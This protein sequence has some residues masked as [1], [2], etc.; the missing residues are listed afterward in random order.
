L[1][2]ADDLEAERRK[3]L[4]C[5]EAKLDVLLAAVSILL[6]AARTDP[7][8]LSSLLHHLTSRPPDEE[9]RK[10]RELVGVEEEYQEC[11]FPIKHV[12]GEKD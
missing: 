1:I 8:H 2:A 12:A 9:S 6:R 7:G 3:E 4:A 10:R 11:L 5:I